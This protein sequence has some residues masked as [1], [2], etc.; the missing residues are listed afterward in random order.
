MSYIDPI[1]PRW[2]FDAA[3]PYR[4]WR[5]DTYGVAVGFAAGGYMAGWDDARKLAA[6]PTR[7]RSERLRRVAARQRW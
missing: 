1:V 4:H 5:G 6:A 7:R 3:K 2:L